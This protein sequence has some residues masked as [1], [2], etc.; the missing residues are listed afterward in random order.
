MCGT[1][2]A[3]GYHQFNCSKWTGRSWKKVHYIVATALAFEIQRLGSGVVDSDFTMKN[4]YAHPTSQKRGYIAVNSDG[5]LQINNAV[6]R[7]ARS[8]F[9][10]EVKVCAVV[11][12]DGYWKA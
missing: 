3:F 9:I 10:V 11:T 7:H 2:S 1:I 12:G 5:H 8:D 6:D 4:D